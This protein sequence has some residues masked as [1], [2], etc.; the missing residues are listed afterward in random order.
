[1]GAGIVGPRDRLNRARNEFKPTKK[2][3]NNNFLFFTNKTICAIQYLWYK[4]KNVKNTHGGMLVLVKL[5]PEACNFTQSK[6][7]HG[8]FS[9]FFNCRNGTKLRKASRIKQNGLCYLI[10]YSFP[11]FQCLQYYAGYTAEHKKVLK[12]QEYGYEMG[13]QLTHLSPGSFK[14]LLKK[15]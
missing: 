14:I 10:F 13:L 1:M 9:R 2:Q 11:L 12:Q 7:L 15:T 4:F 6:L 3:K 5:Q 8:C